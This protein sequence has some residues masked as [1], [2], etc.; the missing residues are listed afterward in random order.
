MRFSE[1]HQSGLTQT[2]A[3]VIRGNGG[4]SPEL[5]CATFQFLLDVLKQKL[6]LEYASR[7]H[8]RVRVLAACQHSDRI[9]NAVCNS[10]L[11]STRDHL[12]IASPDSV[13]NDL[14]QQ[15]TKIQFPIN[16]WER[17]ALSFKRCTGH[18]LHPHGSL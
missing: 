2:D 16:K 6:V 9:R 18:M 10:A 11:E 14:L 1:R 8:N 3:A 7:K 4:V 15:W 17:V 12:R 13:P 5:Q